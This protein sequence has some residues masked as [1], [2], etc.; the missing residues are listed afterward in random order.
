MV[1]GREGPHGV[2]TS[3]TPKGV[4]HGICRDRSM[5]REEVTTSETPKGVEHHKAA[6]GHHHKVLVTTSETPKGVEHIASESLTSRRQ[7]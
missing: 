6:C 2:T 1:A 7:A 4:E 3:E 5:H